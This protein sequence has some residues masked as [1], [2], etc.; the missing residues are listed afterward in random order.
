MLK[1]FAFVVLA[2]ASGWAAPAVSL[3]AFLPDLGVRKAY[4]GYFKDN[5]VAELDLETNRLRGTIS[6]PPG[7]DGP[8]I[9]PDGCRVYVSSGGGLD[10]KR[11]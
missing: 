8:V 10:G 2:F 7:P 5:A 9:T 11:Y 3:A 6:V 4:V 1:Q